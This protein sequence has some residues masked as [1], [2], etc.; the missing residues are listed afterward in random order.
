MAHHVHHLSHGWSFKQ[1]GESE[2][3]WLA[4]DKVP[5]NVHL[6]LIAHGKYVITRAHSSSMPAPE[7]HGL[8]G[9]HG[10]EYQIRS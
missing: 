5:T 7:S 8:T 1:A 2:N 3:A 4:V 6:D 9:A 10:I